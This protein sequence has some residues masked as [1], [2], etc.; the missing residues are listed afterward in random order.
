MNQSE[1]VPGTTVAGQNENRINLAEPGGVGCLDDDYL[2]AQESPCRPQHAPECPRQQALIGV[3][4][5]SLPFDAV[6][7]GNDMTEP[8]Q[9]CH[10]NYGEFD[11]AVV[12]GKGGQAEHASSPADRREHRC[13]RRRDGE[14]GRQYEQDHSIHRK[15]KPPYRAGEHESHWFR[16]S[17]RWLTASRN[18]D[19]ASYAASI[20]PR[21]PEVLR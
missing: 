19:A 8:Q 4:P 17:Q 6:P 9:A 2:K 15:E 3:D 1:G 21:T 16:P 10:D 11:D 5:P 14:D 7:A 18:V 13:D 12:Q 20:R